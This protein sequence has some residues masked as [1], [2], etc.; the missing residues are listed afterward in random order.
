MKA[1]NVDEVRKTDYDG[2]W[3]IVQGKDYC[4]VDKKTAMRVARTMYFDKHEEFEKWKKT[5]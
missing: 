5:L 3:H 4:R 2:L 1:R